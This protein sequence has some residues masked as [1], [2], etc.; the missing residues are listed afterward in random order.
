MMSEFKVGLY[1]KLFDS[2]A[3]MIIFAQFQL[4]PLSH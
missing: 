4:N 3:L 1:K 2:E